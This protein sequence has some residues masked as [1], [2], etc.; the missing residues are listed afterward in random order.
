MTIRIE[1]HRLLA[2]LREHFVRSGFSVQ[3]AGA[4]ALAVSLPDAPDAEQGRREVGAH[5]LVWGVLH[6]EY[7]GE[8]VD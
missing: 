2:E 7:P 1:N 3:A 5:L 6:P 8:I 4:A